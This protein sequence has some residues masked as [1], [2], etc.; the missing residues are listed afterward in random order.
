MEVQYDNKQS[1]KENIILA[2]DGKAE[3]LKKMLEELLR[4]VLLTNQYFLETVPK[5]G[6]CNEPQI[7]GKNPDNYGWFQ[8]HRDNLE[9]LR[10]QI[11]GIKKQVE[12]L[13][14]LTNKNNERR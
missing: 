6:E 12:K 2:I 4:E 1:C 11:I 5:V 13:H 3:D 10:Q 14:I 9:S 7:L 8:N